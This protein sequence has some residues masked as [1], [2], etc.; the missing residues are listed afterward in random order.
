MPLWW[1]ATT[2]ALITSPSCAHCMGTT[3]H[4]AIGGSIMSV[5]TSIV[6][7]N[8]LVSEILF[9]AIEFTV[10]GLPYIYRIYVKI[11]KYR[12]DNL[13]SIFYKFIIYV[14]LI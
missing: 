11:P 9:H 1:Y 5:D 14:I 7:A 12:R 6:C 13:F 4:R 2:A 10:F 3:D 8:G